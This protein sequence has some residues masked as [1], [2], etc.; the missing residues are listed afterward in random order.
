M[1]TPLEANKAIVRRFIEEVVNGRK[2]A[3]ADEFI[4]ADSRDHT[5][6]PNLPPNREGVKLVMGMINSAFPDMHYTIEDMVA[7][8]D[9]VVM[10]FTRRGTHLGALFGMPPSGRAVEWRGMDFFRLADGK[11]VEHWANFD[12]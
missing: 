12:Q 3:A 1:T 8:E 5:L 6:P 11:I 10:R 2:P 7:E 4:A 9:K